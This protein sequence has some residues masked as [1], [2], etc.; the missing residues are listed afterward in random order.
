M[1]IT[2]KRILCFT[3]IL[4]F[5][6]L[7]FISILNVSEVKAGSLWDMQE[8]REKIGEAFDQT[9]EPTDLREVIVNMI[10]IFL[11]FVG[12]IFLIMIILA[13]YKWMTAAGNQDKV[14]EAKSQLKAAIIGIIIILAAYVITEFI[15]EEAR[16]EMFE[17]VW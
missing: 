3:L 12:I 17:E 14:G 6:L 15:A 2:K 9:G 11:T 4:S 13:G 7:Q 16:Q 1:K 5:S 8:G 10:K